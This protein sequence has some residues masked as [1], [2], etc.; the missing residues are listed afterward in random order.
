VVH[1]LAQEMPG[2]DTSLLCFQPHYAKAVAF[3]QIRP[4]GF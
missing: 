3:F 2:T 1:P 4:M